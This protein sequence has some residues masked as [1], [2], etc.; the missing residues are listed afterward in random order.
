M[1]YVKSERTPGPA[2]PKTRIR[3]RVACV[4]EALGGLLLF[5]DIALWV[6]GTYGDHRRI[7][8]FRGMFAGELLLWFRVPAVLFLFAA[9]AVGVLP[10]VRPLFFRIV[11]A[12]VATVLFL[13]A[14][15]VC[16]LPT[17]LVEKECFE[18]RSEDGAH[19]ITFVVTSTLRTRID[20]YERENDFTLRC[21]LPE[22][23]VVLESVPGDESL[24]KWE[25]DGFSVKIEDR[26]IR[27]YY[28][29]V[30][31]ATEMIEPMTTENPEKETA[32]P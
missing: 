26:W 25:S 19:T 8:C 31:T 12:V 4:F 7:F 20:V 13:I 23:Q 2:T 6:F 22:Q 30:P 5:L 16:L 29:D 17:L 32:A 21:L 28:R 14:V 9:F 18:F 24:L 10:A 1:R 3:K 15:G 11:A 27:Y